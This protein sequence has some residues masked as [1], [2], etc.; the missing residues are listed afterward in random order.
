MSTVKLESLGREPLKRE[1]MKR[2]DSKTKW[3]S[4]YKSMICPWHEAVD[5]MNLGE[6]WLRLDLELHPPLE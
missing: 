3:V 1:G 5:R 2:R 4:S 6:R